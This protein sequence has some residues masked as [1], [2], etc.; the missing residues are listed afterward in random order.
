[1]ST[2]GRPDSRRSYAGSVVCERAKVCV[3]LWE[4]LR[5]ARTMLSKSSSSF[6]IRNPPHMTVTTEDEK[7]INVSKTVSS[8]CQC[9]W[10]G[11][12][13]DTRA[14]PSISCFAT[15]SS[16]NGPLAPSNP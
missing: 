6:L 4:C 11:Q 3:S 10:S 14:L 7:V 5:V 12:M 1:M 15:P 13:N 9:A 2:T 16:L 8:L